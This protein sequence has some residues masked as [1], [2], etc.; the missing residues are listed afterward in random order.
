[1]Y[2]V[3]PAVIGMVWLEELG[4]MAQKLQVGS[5]VQKQRYSFVLAVVFSDAC[6]MHR[7]GRQVMHTHCCSAV[8]LKN[9]WM[10]HGAKRKQG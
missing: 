10:V 1:M 4:T 9:G 3:G 8:A 6:S 2:A 5:E 7:H